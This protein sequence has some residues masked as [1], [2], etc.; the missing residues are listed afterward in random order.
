M[1][2]DHIGYAVKKIEKAVL[3]FQNLGYVFEDT[4][5]DDDRNIFIAFGMKDG[6]RIELIAPINKEGSPVDVCLSK[7]GPTPY[8][9]CYKSDS[10]EEDIKRLEKNGYK[11]VIEEMPAIALG[12]AKVCF[13]YNSQIGLVE[14]VEI[15]CG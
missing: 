12:G 5:Q 13:L 11:V 7:N 15:K 10:F 14:I 9:I 1:K 2:I 6:Y 8:H 4:I 3:E